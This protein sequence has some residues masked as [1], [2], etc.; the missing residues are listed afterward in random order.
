MKG[1]DDTS[2][3]RLHPQLSRYHHQMHQTLEELGAQVTSMRRLDFA[4]ESLK[5]F[6]FIFSIQNSA[7]FRN[8]E[9]LISAAAECFGL[10]YLGAPPNV[11][12]LA[13]DKYLANLYVQSLGICAP[14]SRPVSNPESF[15]MP[16]PFEGPY[17][18]KPRFGVNSEDMPDSCVQDNWSALERA[19]LD[20]LGKGIECL[21]EQFI[22][23]DNIGAPHI[24]VAKSEPLSVIMEPRGDGHN[25]LTSS[26]KQAAS[27]FEGRTDI[28]D[29]PAGERVAEYNTRIRE[30]LGPIDYFR[31]DWRLPD[32]SATPYFIEI[33]ICC[34]LSKRSGVAFAASNVG[35]PYNRLVS[36]IVLDSLRR[37]PRLR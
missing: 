6:D 30:D 35:I 22:A 17:I 28:R 3:L 14:L 13:E 10:A 27:E 20:M 23:G 32:K 18:I 15:R 31:T 24:E 16:A 37:K 34:N 33:N 11:R 21:V 4:L 5:N 19:G 26:R 25:I 29:L 9:V 2:E 36:E 8:S 7:P 1:G 12:A